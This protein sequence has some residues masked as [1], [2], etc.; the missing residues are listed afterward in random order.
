MDA[1]SNVPGSRPTSRCSATR[2][3]APSAPR[4]R[5]AI[6]ELAG[7]ALDLTMTIGGEQRLGG[8][9]ADRRGAA[10]QPRAP[11]S[12]ATRDAT[13]EDVR[14]AI[15]ARA[16]GGARLAGAVLRRAGRDLPARRPTCWPGR[17][18]TTLNA[19]TDARP[20]EVGAAG[21]DRRGLRADR[22]PAVQRG[23]RPPALRRAADLVARRVEPDGL[24]A[25]GGLR[26]AI[27]PFNFTA[28]AGNL[29]T[30][31]GADGQRRR[32]EAVADP[33]VRRAL[34][35]AAAGGGRA[36]RRASSTWSPATARRSPRSR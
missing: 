28:I 18:G 13:A 23:L 2:P 35:H 1:I 32:L 12:A 30:A 31:A 29:P 7:A 33:A 25:A 21:G 4:W 22:L 17:G 26:L 10:A 15:D 11:C 19:A 16:G 3:A 24:P 9:D 8:G 6:K 36:C 34:H 14:A 5:T 20:V 27:T